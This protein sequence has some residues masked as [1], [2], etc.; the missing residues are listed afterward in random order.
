MFVLYMLHTHCFFLSSSLHSPLATGSCRWSW[1]LPSTEVNI[2]QWSSRLR[3]CTSEALAWRTTKLVFT[4][5]RPKPAHSSCCFLLEICFLI[6]FPPL[7]HHKSIPIAQASG[8]SLM[9]GSFDEIITTWKSKSGPVPPFCGTNYYK[10]YELFIG[11][12]ARSDVVR[13][14]SG[15]SIGA[16]VCSHRVFS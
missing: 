14:V 6:D 8:T 7:P 12:F 2:N 11:F 15:R 10:H 3:I 13:R 4:H 1:L 16:F 5:V 9:W